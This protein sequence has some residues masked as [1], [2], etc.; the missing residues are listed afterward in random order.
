M[1]NQFTKFLNI[2]FNSQLLQDGKSWLQ[3]IYGIKILFTSL[4]FT[5]ITQRVLWKFGSSFC[6]DNMW[7]RGG[8][9]LKETCLLNSPLW[10]FN[11]LA[12]RDWRI[13]R[14]EI[15]STFSIYFKFV[16]L[17]FFLPQNH[18][19]TQHWD[20]Y[21]RLSYLDTWEQCLCF[22][23]FSNSN[24]RFTLSYIQT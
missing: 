2:V 24:A 3:H 15:S 9:V 20:R 17:F 14:R 1:N 8:G 12:L 19:F 13:K 7:Q 11:G 6:A 21:L 10:S 22:S 18:L 16:F 4:A 5:R 23:L